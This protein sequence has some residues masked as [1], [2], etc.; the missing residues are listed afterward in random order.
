MKTKKKSTLKDLPYNKKIE[1]V[2]PQ[3]LFTFGER[4]EMHHICHRL[5]SI[6]SIVRTTAGLLPWGTEVTVVDVV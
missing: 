1:D 3:E 4:S 5:S 6:A 2:T